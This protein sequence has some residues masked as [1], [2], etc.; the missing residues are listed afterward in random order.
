[1]M[2]DIFKDDMHLF[3][4]KAAHK[5]INKQYDV[6]LDFDDDNP[7]TH[8]RL[9]IFIN[10]NACIVKK[11]ADKYGYKSLSEKFVILESEMEKKKLPENQPLNRKLSFCLNSNNIL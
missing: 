7:G 3:D 2:N 11:I 5:G 9:Q 8:N 6:L 4:K 10:L 1:M